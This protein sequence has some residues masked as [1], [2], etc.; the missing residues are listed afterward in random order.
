MRQIFAVANRSRTSC[1]LRSLWEDILRLLTPGPDRPAIPFCPAIYV[2]APQSLGSHSCAPMETENPVMHVYW[3]MH[4][5]AFLNTFLVG[6]FYLSAP[7]PIP[8]RQPAARFFIAIPLFISSQAGD[9]SGTSLSPC[10]RA[11]LSGRRCS[12]TATVAW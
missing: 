5:G 8:G 4:N 6:V 12:L 10:L 1:K 9:T 2:A 11:S 3:R 7:P